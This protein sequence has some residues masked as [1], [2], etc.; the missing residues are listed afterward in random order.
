MLEAARRALVERGCE[1]ISPEVFFRFPDG[2]A[3]ATGAALRER[4][5]RMAASPPKLH[6]QLAAEPERPEPT[7]DLVSSPEA[8]A[9]APVTQRAREPRGDSSAHSFIRRLKAP[10]LGLR[11]YTEDDAEV[12]FGRAREV[13]RVV[14]RLERQRLAAVIGPRSSGKTSLVLAGVGRAL[15]EGSVERLGTAWAVA[16]V[17]VDAEPLD[18]L[19]DE[20]MDVAQ[21]LSDSGDAGSEDCAERQRLIAAS[22]DGASDSVHRAAEHALTGTSSNLLL[23]VDQVE[24]LLRRPSRQA[25]YFVQSLLRTAQMHD[26]EGRPRVFVVFVLRDEAIDGSA[27]FPGLS[28][29]FSTGSVMLGRPAREQ[30]ARMIVEPAARVGWR[31][32]PALRDQLLLDLESERMPVPLLSHVMH[33][34]AAR[35]GH[36]QQL[37]IADYVAL[38]G[39][40]SAIDQ[41]AELLYGGDPS[42]GIEPLEGRRARLAREMFQRLLQWDDGELRVCEAS[43]A[44]LAEACDVAVDD[45]DLRAVVQRFS[46][47]ASPLLRPMPIGMEPWGDTALEATDFAVLGYW[48][49]LRDWGR[50]ARRDAQAYQALVSTALASTTWTSAT[51]SVTLDEQPGAGESSETE[52]A[53]AKDLLVEPQLTRVLRWWEQR[54]PTLGW[55]KR[56]HAPFLEAAAETGASQA[57]YRDHR[58]LFTSAQRLIERSQRHAEQQAEAERQRQLAAAQQVERFERKRRAWRRSIGAVSLLAG[59]GFLLFAVQRQ[60]AHEQAREAR[61]RYSTLDIAKQRVEAD[62]QRLQGQLEEKTQAEQRLTQDNQRL[63]NER[64]QLSATVA[65]QTQTIE[66]LELRNK[67]ITQAHDAA[68]R[69]NQATQ[70]ELTQAR[71]QLTQVQA[72]YGTA[73]NALTVCR[74][75]LV[76]SNERAARCENSGTTSPSAPGVNSGVGGR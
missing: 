13:Q 49:R 55:A 21:R 65:E 48:K 67:Q 30:L 36:D 6:S 17:L 44:E 53:A 37:D 12:F 64:E 76:Q 59:T 39:P 66:Q 29:A 38:G 46:T 61:Q 9:E 5:S 11:P 4:M 56:H 47:G 68:L 16:H 41:H 70:A 1:R 72:Q 60:Q 20:L 74:S 32:T 75:Q 28:S 58:E 24:R 27:A 73:V 23:V 7:L 69:A 14:E 62:A 42:L 19:R 71:D 18:A 45:S 35:P 25:V 31:V 40:R 26:V 54:S 51:Q 10:Y 34:L 63:T 22:L 33:A 2:R 52:V 43:V 3:L 15:R 50:R 57:R 8:G